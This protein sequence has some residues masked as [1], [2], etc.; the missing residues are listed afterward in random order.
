MYIRKKREAEA[1]MIEKY[2]IQIKGTRPL[3]MHSC[4]SMLEENNRT[5]RSKEYDP[6]VEAEKALYKDGDGGIIVPS[7]CVLS[8]LKEAA[9]NYQIPGKGKRTFKNYIFAGVQIEPGNISLIS[10]NWVIDL[11]TVVVNRS[12][13]VRARP[14]FDNWILEFTIEI[15]D[16]IITP[17]NIKQII[18][19]AGKYNGLLDF[20]PLYGLF[21]LVN[22]KP[23]EE[24]RE[25][26]DAHP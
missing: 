10:D 20:R 24:E 23:I 1:I 2:K 6:K 5:T 15:V 8:C 9:K 26:V 17:D 25:K 21:E 11:K 4:N 19:D 13:I 14:R 7:F 18:I 12:R 16:P 22:F 3:L